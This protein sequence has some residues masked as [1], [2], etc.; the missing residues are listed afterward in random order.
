MTSIFIDTTAFR[1]LFDPK[2]AYAKKAA[3]ILRRLPKTVKLI[4]TDY[5]IDE[6]YTGLLTRSGYKYALVFDRVF[7]KGDWQI[8]WISPQRFIAAQDIFR[9]FNKDKC[10]SFT[11]CSSFAVIK[12]LKISAAFSFDNNFRQMGIKVLD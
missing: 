8:E 7:I 12:E 3:V 10:W 9:R 4:T 11:D 1:S 5:I 2:D 6:T